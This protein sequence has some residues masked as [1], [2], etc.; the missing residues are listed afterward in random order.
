[1][2]VLDLAML[3]AKTEEC[4][5]AGVRR[6]GKSS[7]SCRSLKLMATYDEEKAM[8]DELIKAAGQKLSAMIRADR[9]HTKFCLI[10]R[11]IPPNLPPNVVK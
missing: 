8:Y 6:K 1:M 4:K 10:S 3:K 2:E 9:K 7:R 5:V 11:L